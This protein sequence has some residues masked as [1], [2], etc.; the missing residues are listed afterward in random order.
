MVSGTKIK[1]IA[2]L[3]P[4]ITNKPRIFFLIFTLLSCPLVIRPL[5]NTTGLVI[6]SIIFQ[7]LQTVLFKTVRWSFY[8]VQLKFVGLPE[9]I[10][11]SSAASIVAKWVLHRLQIFLNSRLLQFLNIKRLQNKQKKSRNSNANLLHNRLGSP[12]CQ[13]WRDSLHVIS[14]FNRQEGFF[15]KMV[16]E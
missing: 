1:L 6:F 13:C 15:D 16:G 4:L 3:N 7:K 2:I 14:R 10:N 11:K 12:T 8:W 9:Q 5:K